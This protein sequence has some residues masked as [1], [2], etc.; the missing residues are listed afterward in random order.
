MLGSQLSV[1]RSLGL[2]VTSPWSKMVT[3]YF[4]QLDTGGN[5][6]DRLWEVSEEL[7]LYINGHNLTWQH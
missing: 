7:H 1:C 6:E 5:D 2:L 4:R 3:L